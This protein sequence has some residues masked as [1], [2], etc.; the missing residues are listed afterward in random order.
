M[1]DDG[2]IFVGQDIENFSVLEYC[3]LLRLA[4]FTSSQAANIQGTNEM[5]PA[6]RLESYSHTVLTKL[7]HNKGFRLNG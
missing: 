7:I 4:S 3:S 2:H 5:T 6:P 1:G